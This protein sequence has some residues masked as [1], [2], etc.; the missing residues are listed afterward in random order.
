MDRVG[1]AY[2]PV[3]STLVTAGDRWPTAPGPNANDTF[4]ATLAPEARKAYFVALYGVPDPFAVDVA[5][6]GGCAG[7]ANAA[8]PGVFAEAAALRA[9]L[10]AMRRGVRQ[11]PATLAAAR[12]WQACLGEPY[13]NPGELMGAI[14]HGVPVPV[15]TVS[16]DQQLCRPAYQV[17]VDLVRVHHED[18][19]AARFKDRL[20]VHQ[21]RMARAEALLQEL[22]T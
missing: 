6:A 19:F 3:T 7:A 16:R 14:D 10:E 13:A 8:V 4:V 15:A 20:A 12:Q 1:W 21:A 2:V 5:A 18:Q 17:A 9:E 11:D 22:G